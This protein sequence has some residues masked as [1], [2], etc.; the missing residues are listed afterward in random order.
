MQYYTS[1]KE[2]SVD[3]DDFEM[4][5]IALRTENNFL[6]GFYFD[7]DERTFYESAGLYG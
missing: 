6:Q 7:Q 4:L 2:D 5:E 3:E 1:Q